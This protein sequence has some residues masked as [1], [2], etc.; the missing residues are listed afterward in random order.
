[1]LRHWNNI[2]YPVR[3]P[4]SCTDSRIHVAR[5]V[6][7]Q[8]G[9]QLIKQDASINIERKLPHTA[10]GQ[11]VHL[12]FSQGKQHVT[13]G[14]YIVTIPQG[15]VFADGIVITPENQ[16]LRDLSQ[17][18]G[19]TAGDHWVCRRGNL[20]RPVYFDG[21]LA[22]LASTAGNNYFH[23][24]FDI[25]PRYE[26]LSDQSIDAYYVAN[27]NRFQQAYLLKAGIPP[28][29]II[30]AGKHNHIQAKTLFVPSL[31]GNT[32]NPT[33]RSCQF[34]RSISGCE[35]WSGGKRRIYLTRNDGGRRR[36]INENEITPL[37]EHY[38]FEYIAPA[39]LS[40][41]QQIRLFAEAEVIIGPHGAA[42]SNL[43]YANPGTRVIE[44]FS[45]DYVN[46]CYW[47]LAD[48]CQLEYY[49]LVNQDNSAITNAICSEVSQDIKVDH[50]ALTKLLMKLLGG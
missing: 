8:T 20:P 42:L 7:Q 38:G 17:V 25:L 3:P 5:Y 32:G 45:P 41:E 29:R 15:R 50:D 47:A 43:V 28:H 2:R 23:W 31:P 6:S 1:M 21:T 9:L 46:V 33:P 36:I 37:L 27:E 44:F 11:A 14:T 48:L 40:V 4:A 30:N 39:T 10:N 35:K 22:V 24:L 19:G 12:R 26:L 16:V 13:P 34:L 49:Y 18:I